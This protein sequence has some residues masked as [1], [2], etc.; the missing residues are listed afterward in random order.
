MFLQQQ[1]L[2]AKP[3]SRLGR[4]VSGFFFFTTI[5]CITQKKKTH[6]HIMQKAK[7]KNVISIFYI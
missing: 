5:Q 7:L 3:L 2:W 4:L 6:W 1:R